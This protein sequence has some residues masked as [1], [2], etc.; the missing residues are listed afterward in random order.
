MIRV[1]AGIMASWV[2]SPS[3]QWFRGNPWW[4]DQGPR[5]LG[6]HWT[7]GSILTCTQ[8]VM[9]MADV[10]FTT[11]IYINRYT[12]YYHYHYYYMYIYI[13]IHIALHVMDIDGYPMISSWQRLPR[14]TAH[15]AS[16]G[17]ILPK[18]WGPEVWRRRPRVSG[19][20]FRTPPKN[21]K[22]I[23]GCC[24]VIHF[25]FLVQADHR[26]KI[27][28]IYIIYMYTV[29]RE[30]FADIGWPAVHPLQPDKLYHQILTSHWWFLELAM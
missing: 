1:S 13:Y 26:G 30:H 29:W 5:G 6:S 10:M 8:M 21:G 4:N 2:D 7:D 9:F 16:P 20:P 12:Y 17:E 19:P 11:Y 15:L 14:R 27:I 25:F 23:P 18:S 24:Q 28:Y 22:C 3:G